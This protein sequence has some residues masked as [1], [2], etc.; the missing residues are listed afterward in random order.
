MLRKNGP[1]RSLTRPLSRKW[2]D[3]V[4]FRYESGRNGIFYSLDRPSRRQSAHVVQNPLVVSGWVVDVTHRAA[5]RVRIVLAGRVYDA[6]KKIRQD[7][8]R[9]FEATAALPRACGFEEIID[10]PVGMHRLKIEIDIGDGAWLTL[11]SA[12][13]FN[14]PFHRQH[15][16]VTSSYKRWARMEQALLAAE[17]PELQKHCAMMLHRPKFSIIVELGDPADF[18]AT[19][20]SIHRQIYPHWAVHAL[21]PEG[22]A[23]RRGL[24]TLAGKVIH[25]I[26]APE[27]DGDFLVFVR[28]GDKLAGNALYEFASVLNADPGLDMIYGDESCVVGRRRRV[29]PFIK[30]DWS[31][32]YLETFNYVGHPACYRASLARASAT[33]GGYYDFVLRFT[34]RTDKIHHVRRMLLHRPAMHQS[35]DRADREADMSAL[36]DRL[37]RTGRAGNREAGRDRQGSLR[38]HS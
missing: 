35:S 29:E 21:A 26:S 5:P 7:V 22:S 18:R 24:S 11:Y 34:E 37:H 15:E 10:L 2:K 3:F 9:T 4:R 27:V 32:D 30:P 16:A 6:E 25:D 28:A 33:K 12:L 8:Q 19:E 38:T 20:E 17:M 36:K 13:V 31:P 23:S 1:L 14:L